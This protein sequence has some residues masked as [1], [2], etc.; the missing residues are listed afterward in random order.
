MSEEQVLVI[1]ASRL[2]VLRPIEGFRYFDN[3]EKDYV[4]DTSA[5]LFMPRSEAERNPEYKQLIP[6]VIFA[7]ENSIF[8]YRR[9]GGGEKRLEGNLSVG[10]G[11][12]INPVDFDSVDPYMA[13]MKRELAEEVAIYTEFEEVTGGLLYDPSTEVGKVHLGIVHAMECSSE[14]IHANE[15]SLADARFMDMYE[16]TNR[17][18]EFEA[19]SKFAIEGIMR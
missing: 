14:S 7:C 8:T 3:G 1:P 6:Y 15:S 11:G 5:M 19:W 17:M 10:V 9:S 16:V 13:G 2:S 18:D 4:L 12:H